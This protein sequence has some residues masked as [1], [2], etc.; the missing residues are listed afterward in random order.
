MNMDRDKL[1]DAA[2]DA[3]FDAAKADAPAPSDAFLA[4]L[5]ADAEAARPV[6][7]PAMPRYPEPTVFERLKGWFAV[8][9]LSGAAALGV[10]IGF[11]MPDVVMTV[12]PLSDE[13]IELSAYLPGAD[14]TVLSE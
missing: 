12:A 10:W 3:L 8:S 7:A 14:L 5:N 9:G 4:R 6:P 2:L 13:V 1:D 11:A